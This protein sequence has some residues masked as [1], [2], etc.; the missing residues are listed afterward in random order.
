M[1]IDSLGD[2]ITKRSENGMF[3]VW[4]VD[5]AS[6]AVTAVLRAPPEEQAAILS[7]FMGA[8]PSSR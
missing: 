6:V 5:G 2:E 1:H 3:R 7:V 8:T 4:G